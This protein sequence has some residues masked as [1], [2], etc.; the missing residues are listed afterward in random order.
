M[1]MTLRPETEEYLTAVERRL[2]KRFR[3]RAD[4]GMIIDAADASAASGDFERIVFLAKF[5]TN[6]FGILR[7]SGV[8]PEETSNLTRELETSL[9]EVADRFRRLLTGGVD[10]SAAARFDEQ[11][12]TLSSTSLES[13]REL[14]SELTWVKNRM[15][16]GDP[17]P[18]RT[19]V[20]P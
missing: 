9:R 15:L 14:L 8:S 10:G 3:H 1:A 4:V 7:R 5:V 11:F 16:D 12:L 2:G 6:A 19:S 18:I 20:S 17:P 13:L